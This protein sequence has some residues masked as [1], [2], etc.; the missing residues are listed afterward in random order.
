[1]WPNLHLER[2]LWLLCRESI[3]GLENKRCRRER[4]W[5]LGLGDGERQ[6][7]LRWIFEREWIRVG[8]DWLVGMRKGKYQGWL[9]CSW[10][11]TT[12]GLRYHSWIPSMN[13]KSCVLNMSLRSMPTSMF[14]WSDWWSIHFSILALIF[15]SHLFT[16]FCLFLSQVLFWKF[17]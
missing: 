15:D 6:K 12:G 1:M 9:P 4:W 3:G 5:W 14:F 7:V 11:R 8:S 10:T 17:L 2:S 16:N 13:I